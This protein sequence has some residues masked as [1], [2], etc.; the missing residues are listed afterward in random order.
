MYKFY[1]FYIKAISITM[2]WPLL[3]SVFLFAVAPEAA[4]VFINDYYP[5]EYEVGSRIPIKANSMISSLHPGEAEDYYALNFCRPHSD[6][7]KNARRAENIGEI[8]IGDKVLPTLYVVEMR[9]DRERLEVCNKSY[10]HSDI[11][12]FK[13]FVHAKYRV[14]WMLD[15]LPNLQPLDL[16]DELGS[17]RLSMYEQCYDLG[18]ASDSE[19]SESSCSSGTA[20][21]YSHVTITVNFHDSRIVSFYTVPSKPLPLQDSKLDVEWTYSVKWREVEL[22][23]GSR[24]DVYTT[25]TAAE[26][27]V[28]LMSTL[29]SMLLIFFAGFYLRY[30]LGRRI[31]KNLSDGRTNYECMELK[32]G[33]HIVSID[34]ELQDI[35]VSS[36]IQQQQQQSDLSDELPGWIQVSGNVYFPPSCPELLCALVA[37]GIQL[38]VIILFTAL[39]A[40]LGIVYAAH[41][42]LLVNCII[43]SFFVTSSVCGYVSA[44]LY[45]SMALRRRD[46]I[47]NFLISFF[48]FP[49]LLLFIIFI[50]NL[51]LRSRHSSSGVYWTTLGFI[52]FSWL[53]I[54]FFTFTMGYFLGKRQRVT[55]LQ[56]DRI[57]RRVPES[58][59]TGSLHHVVRIGLGILSFVTLWIPLKFIYMSVWG[60]M[61]YELYALQWVSILIWLFFTAELCIAYV[62]WQL[63][64]ENHRWWWS[65]YATGIAVTLPTLLYSITYYAL[66]SDITSFVSI[67][68]YFGYAT[69]F[70]I[71]VMLLSGSVCFLASYFFVKRVC[72]LFKVD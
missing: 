31:M 19:C 32:E 49:L 12:L 36:D 25:A 26:R 30:K 35:T 59:A 18:Y 72:V 39:L 37:S 63:N 9:I 27:S 47:I 38:I 5:Q 68:I 16:K 11:E 55:I 58:R 7:I 48:L 60:S 15:S 71:V 21:L 1:F 43:I 61:F 52:V 70:C 10:S 51:L 17:H 40:L 6:K 66:N 42:G 56:T 46:D 4:A 22:R 29:G 41:R 54:S 57:M 3:L 33:V 44:W 24:W 34:V 62:F 69:V 13:K 64:A 45:K 65:S 28:Y 23:M 67:V 2:N 8:L 20:Y 53:C 14:C 50:V